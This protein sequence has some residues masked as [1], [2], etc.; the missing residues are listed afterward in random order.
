[1]KLIPEV[2]SYLKCFIYKVASRV[3]IVNKGIAG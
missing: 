2:H 3:A 1:V